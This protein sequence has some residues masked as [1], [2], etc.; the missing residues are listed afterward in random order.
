MNNT[1]NLDKEIARLIGLHTSLHG[2]NKVTAYD[3]TEDI[4]RQYNYLNR[5]EVFEKV[6]Y[7]LKGE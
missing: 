7:L 1:T 2:L 6:T 3:I 5:T 4:M